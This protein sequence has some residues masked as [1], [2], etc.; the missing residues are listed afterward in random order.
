MVLK[1]SLVLPRSI[2][3]F[4]LERPVI[5]ELGFDTR[6]DGPAGLDRAHIIVADGNSQAISGGMGG[7]NFVAPVADD[8]GSP[9]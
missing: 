5:P 3:I 6:T 8:Q 2:E 7:R 4:D 9:D 1:L